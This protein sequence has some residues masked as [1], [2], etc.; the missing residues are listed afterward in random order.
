MKPSAIPE[1]IDALVTIGA[2]VTDTYD[3]PPATDANKKSYLA[4]G[5]DGDPENLL[6]EF[7]GTDQQEYAYVGS[8]VQS[9]LGH[10]VCAAVNWSG[11][12]TVK[13]RRDAAYGLVSDF[14]DAL[15]T[16]HRTNP[17][18]QALVIGCWVSAGGLT[19]G[20]TGDGVTAR[21]VFTVNFTAQI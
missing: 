12:K 13:A 6:G 11:D 10:V 8:D 7:A 14:N 4:I 1:L 2:T 15:R 19:Q 17:T 5:W 16:A 9:E 3:G 18:L 21:V 20:Q